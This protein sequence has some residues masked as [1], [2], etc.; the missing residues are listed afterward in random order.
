M[1]KEITALSWG[2]E[3]RS[4]PAHWW[5]VGREWGK[6]QE[7]VRE[8]QFF[9]RQMQSGVTTKLVAERT[10][11]PQHEPLP[12]LANSS[13]RF[14]PKP[15]SPHA[16]TRKCWQFSVLTSC[17]NRNRT[18]RVSGFMAT[19]RVRAKKNLYKYQTIILVRTHPATPLTYIYLYRNI[20]HNCFCAS[21]IF[22]IVSMSRFPSDS[23]S[24][25]NFT[26]RL[27]PYFNELK[28]PFGFILFLTY[29]T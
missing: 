12:L 5:P 25:L 2:D 26:T 13:Q 14:F 16:Q 4:S 7:E 1:Q 15:P 17:G 20:Y 11:D 24:L 10:N 28:C 3:E 21:A 6:D 19:C 8:Q 9:N 18:V 22:K 29:F 23:K 27:T